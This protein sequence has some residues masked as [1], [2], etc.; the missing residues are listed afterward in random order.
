M[1]LAR[2]RAVSRGSD[3]AA[4]RFAPRVETA[5]HATMKAQARIPRIPPTCRL[6]AV[7]VHKKGTGIEFASSSCVLRPEVVPGVAEIDFLIRR[8]QVR[9]PNRLT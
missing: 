9:G 6:S 5:S 2:T 3:T 7:N 4:S 1:T 8:E